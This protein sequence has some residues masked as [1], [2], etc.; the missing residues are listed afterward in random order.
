MPESA[1]RRPVLSIAEGPVPS[2]AE[3]A[4]NSQ[5][6][7]LSTTPVWQL[8]QA[9]DYLV[10]CGVSTA[11]LDA[12][13][14][15]AE[16]LGTDRTGLYQRQPSPLDQ[17]EIDKFWQ[18][19]ERRGKREPLPYIIGRQEF[20]SLEF[21]VDPRVLIPRPET[22]EIRGKEACLLSTGARPDL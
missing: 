18:L 13:V 12:E 6:T 16:A 15:L 11:C 5:K 1:N 10:E 2:T 4:E 14:L 21:F 7:S 17:E 3:G 20:W 8:R 9:T 22:E 19:V